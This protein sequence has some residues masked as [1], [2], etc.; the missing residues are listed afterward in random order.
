MATQT[1]QRTISPNTRASGSNRYKID[2][3]NLLTG[4]VLI[5][6]IDHATKSFKKQF[7]FSGKDIGHKKSISFSVDER[8]NNIDISWSGV[9]PILQGKSIAI[10]KVQVEKQSDQKGEVS[11]SDGIQS[12]NPILDEHTK[13]VILG[14]MPGVESLKQQAYYSHPRNLFWKLIAEL[15]G[16][17]VPLNYDDRTAFLL[18]HKIGLWDICKSCV[19]EGSLDSNISEETPTDLK[20]LVAKYPNIE[21]L[22]FNGQKAEKLYSKHFGSLSNV[23]ELSLPSSSPANASVSWVEKV[24]SWNKL[25]EHI[26]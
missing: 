4:D 11:E 24:E 23:K 2:T 6:E 26:N 1:R 18:D 21:C 5:V 15:T 22:A 20:A 13:L 10:N 19:R 8:G 7:T 3:R 12:L 14:T 16:K 17:D 25:I 9:N